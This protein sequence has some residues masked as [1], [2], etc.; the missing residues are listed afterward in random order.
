MN[1]ILTGSGETREFEF[2]DR[3]F[4]RIR[5]LIYEHAGISLCK[6]KKEMVYN[7][8][9]KRLRA[10]GLRTFRDYLER[11]DRG[12]ETELEAFG[13]ALTTN[14]TA[15]FREP[16]HFP[17]LAEH[18]KQHPARQVA[19]WTCA[20]STGEEA[21]SIAMTMVDLFDDFRPPVAILATDIDTSVL[22]KAETGVYPMERVESMSPDKV[23][24]FFLKGVG[25]NEGFVKVRDE[26]RDMISFRRINLQDES[27]PLRGPLQAIFCRNVMIYFDKHTQY[28][29]LEKFA[30]LLRPDGLLFA[31][32]SESFFH[33]SELFVPCGRTVYKPR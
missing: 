7:R 27:W 6:M 19:I 13:N 10:L 5:K 18:I 1:R 8:L 12:D 23:R 30:P 21:Y 29:I 4:E 16:H 3:D 31:G 15:F 14:L 11:L 9:T 24:R 32:H 20:A 28:K 25:K 26:L 22:A 2:T 33:A 17:V